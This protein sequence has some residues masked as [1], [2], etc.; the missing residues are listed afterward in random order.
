MQKIA[1]VR[2]HV[3]DTSRSGDE[4]AGRNDTDGTKSL[5]TELTG[6]NSYIL[7]FGKNYF[8]NQ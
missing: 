5:I 2:M 1:G 3:T 4:K 8:I 7:Y 6:S